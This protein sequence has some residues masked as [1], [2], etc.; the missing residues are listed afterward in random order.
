VQ[1][2][3]K[4]IPTIQVA[5]AAE[6]VSASDPG[7]AAETQALLAQSAASPVA[8]AVP[9]VPQDPAAAALA[10]LAAEHADR[11]LDRDFEVASTRS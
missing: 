7:L 8:V 10:A 9:L 5:S 11:S 3:K 1:G 2:K 6:A 4:A